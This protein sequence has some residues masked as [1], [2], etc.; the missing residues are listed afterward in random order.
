LLEKIILQRNTILLLGGLAIFGGAMSVLA[1]IYS[2]YLPNL[3]M[4]TATSVSLD[5]VANILS[6]KSHEDHLVGSTLGQFFIPFHIFGWLL[7]FLALAPANMT[8]R[9]LVLVFSVYITIIGA[10][11]HASLL[12]AGAIA[13]SGEQKIVNQVG[14]FFNITS[15]TLVAGVVIF[16]CVVAFLILSR[17]S[18]YPRWVV[19]ISPLGYLMI[20][21]LIV[22]ALPVTSQSISAFITAT[23]FNLPCTLLHI[24][25]TVVLLRQSKQPEENS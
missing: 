19:L 17:R 1:D 20:T 15:Y 14:E 21:T 25:T 10:S 11:L 4:S 23:G 12:Y 16:G 2:A 24:A 8:L 9:L 18:L 3:A 22:A 13:R 5:S 6:A 7:L